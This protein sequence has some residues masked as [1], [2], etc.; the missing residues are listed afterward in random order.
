MAGDWDVPLVQFWCSTCGQ[1]MQAESQHRGSLIP[2]PRCGAAMMIPLGNPHRSAPIIDPGRLPSLLEPG[3]PYSPGPALPAPVALPEAPAIR[4]SSPRS[5]RK[6]RGSNAVSQGLQIIAG[7]MIGLAIAYYLLLKIEE[8]QQQA[9]MAAKAGQAAPER[10]NQRQPAAPAKPKEPDRAWPPPRPPKMKREPLVGQQDDLPIPLDNLDMPLDLRPLQPPVAAKAAPPLAF[11]QITM[12]SGATFLENELK[13]PSNWLQSRFPDNAPFYAA[14]REH[15]GTAEGMYSFDTETGRLNGSVVMLDEKEQVIRLAEYQSGLRHGELHLWNDSGRLV[16]GQ[17]AR[18]HAHGFILLFR[19]NRPWLIQRW[20]AG[21]GGSNLEESCLVIYRD[22]A[23]QA[24]PKTKLT[25][26]QTEEVFQAEAML[27]SLI[28]QFAQDE[29]AIRNG[30][31]K[32]YNELMENIRRRR[33]SIRSANHRQER[34]AELRMARETIL[35]NN[36]AVQRRVV[37]RHIANI[38]SVNQGFIAVPKP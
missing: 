14:Q 2:C 17:Y 25:E 1:P 21:T 24:V 32:W 29:D 16:F 23:Y 4:T 27:A 12:P 8:R 18:N 34:L 36:R 19:Q 11:G 20:T 31:Y 9:V 26:Q 13:L 22:N 6:K 5:S 38:D 10:P 35:Q 3:V 33:A 15:D 28:S 7:G 37:D 30:M